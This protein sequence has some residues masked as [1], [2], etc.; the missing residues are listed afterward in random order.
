M[1]TLITASERLIKAV[2]ESITVTFD[3]T[4]WLASGETLASVTSVVQST[5][6]EPTP[7]AL[8]IGTPAVNSAAITIDGV[9]IAIGKA[10]QVLV[11]VG[12]DL[13]HYKLTATVVTTSPQT[14]IL[15]GELFVSND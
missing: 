7:T 11:S 5:E 12:Q 13:V 15:N 3:F 1:P 10:V 2:A 14:F 6:F 8:T 4:K 9:E